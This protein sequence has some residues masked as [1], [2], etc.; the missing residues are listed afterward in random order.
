LLTFDTPLPTKQQEQMHP[1]EHIRK[2]ASLTPDIEQRLLGMMRQKHYD[3]GETLQGQ[4]TLQANTFYLMSGS[5]RLFYTQGGR[6]HTVS[7]AFSDQFVV[8][9]P[10]FAERYGDTLAVQFLEP[11]SL[12]FI[13]NRT[14]RN[15]LKESGVVDPNEGLIFL[16]AALLQYSNS[17]EERVDVMQ[18]LNAPERYAWAIRRFPR[19]TECAST[20]QI[21]S[22]LGL[23]KETL[24]RIKNGH[25]AVR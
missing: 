6:E 25:Y 13:P 2:F 3:K 16:S 10:Y 19:L 15:Q 12:I 9:P 21:A 14:V 17:L 23:T 8:V 24:Y 1:I 4:Q 5:T 18:T 7:F 20:A 11:S 22:F